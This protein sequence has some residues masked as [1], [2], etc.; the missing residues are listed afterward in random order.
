ML[1][2]IVVA[3]MFFASVFFLVLSF[4]LIS[5]DEESDQRRI[6]AHTSSP[7]YWFLE[8]K[9]EIQRGDFAQMWQMGSSDGAVPWQKVRN[10]SF[11]LK[12]Q[13]LSF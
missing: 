13:F 6:C 7:E 4:I 12:L 1:M 3:Y 9:L 5:A 11:E 10:Y 8:G 2:L